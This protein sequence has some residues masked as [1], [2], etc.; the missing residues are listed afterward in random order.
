MSRFQY[1]EKTSNSLLFLFMQLLV[2]LN[3][4]FIL[5]WKIW[6]VAIL[7]WDSHTVWHCKCL[8]LIIPYSVV[9]YAWVVFI[10]RN[11]IGLLHKYWWGPSWVWSYGSWIYN[12]LCNQCLSSLKLWVRTLFRG[13][14]LTWNNIM[15]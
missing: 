11:I 15:W 13:G 7:F 8:N 14:V 9:Q 2:M 1:I 12:Y 5:N 10:L 3:M 6:K 4:I